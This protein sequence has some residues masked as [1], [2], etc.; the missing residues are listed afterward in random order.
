MDRFGIIGYPLGHSKSPAAF[1]A[2][3]GGKWQYDL[4]EGTDFET[5]WQR[6]L[7]SYKAVTVT[8]PYKERAFAKADII[9]PEAARV[10]ATNLV[11]KTP[12]GIRAYNSD[13]QG[14]KNLLAE[15][16]LGRGHTAIVIGCGGAGKAAAAAA[17]DS[18]LETVVANRTLSRA[19]AL[20]SH[21][22]VRI[23]PF[24]AP[25]STDIVIYTIPGPISNLERFR[26]PLVL[27]ACYA[28]PS[29]T[30]EL[31]RKLGAE[32]LGGRV[33]HYHQAV[34]SYGLMTGLE[35]DANSV[36]KVYEF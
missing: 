27:E 20:A 15:K 2:A 22:G 28:N 5:L 23:H 9:M 7:D 10:L 32:Y 16:G 33:W 34:S 19:E 26:S 21:L 4:L 35:P 12:E 6:F 25:L 24:D 13:Y 29:Y 14:V 18:G 8:A 11:I 30:P 36:R 1:K 17:V 31:L 3:Y